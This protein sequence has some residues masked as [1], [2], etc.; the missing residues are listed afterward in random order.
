MDLWFDMAPYRYK[1][2]ETPGPPLIGSEFQ[3]NEN[4]LIV[5]KPNGL[6]YRMLATSIP[7]GSSNNIEWLDVPHLASNNKGDLSIYISGI[8]SKPNISMVLVGYAARMGSHPKATFT[9]YTS[10][11]RTE[12]FKHFLTVNKSDKAQWSA[13]FIWVPV[14]GNELIIHIDDN[15]NTGTRRLELLAAM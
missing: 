13:H 2:D 11:E 15:H 6:T 14:V 3:A 8:F 1:I 5:Q 7:L 10:T 12:D 4:W 9:F